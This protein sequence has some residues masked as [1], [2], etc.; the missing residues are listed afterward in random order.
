MQRFFPTLLRGDS[1]TEPGVA[2]L[3]AVP[4][5]SLSKEKSEKEKDS[6]LV[7]TVTNPRFMLLALSAVG[8]LFAGLAWACRPL[9]DIIDDRRPS[10]QKSQDLSPSYLARSP[11]GGGQYGALRRS[12]S[13]N[14]AVKKTVSWATDLQTMHGGPSDTSPSDSESAVVQGSGQLVAQQVTAC[15]RQPQ[16]AAA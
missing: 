7:K 11:F 14:N 8:L 13:R 2:L 15:Q 9:L 10:Q 6:Q 1:A 12:S 3:E 5:V 16:A 4:P